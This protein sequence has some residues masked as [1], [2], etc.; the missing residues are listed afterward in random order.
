MVIECDVPVPVDDGLVLRAD[1]FAPDGRGPL[2]GDPHLRPLREGARLPGRLRRPVAAHDGAAP[3]R[4]AAARATSTRTGRSS[5]RRSGCRTATPASGWTRGA[6]AGRRAVLDPFSAGRPAIS[7]SASSGRRRSHGAAARSGLN[8]VSYYAMNQWHVAA[9]QPA[10]PG[11]DLRLGG[12]RRLLPGRHPPRRDPVLLLG[13]LVRQAG[14]RGPA[15]GRGARPAQRRSPARPWP[16]RRRSAGDELAAARVPLRR[17]DRAPT[18]STTSFYRDRSANWERITVPLLTAANW[19]GQGLHTRGNF[20]GFTQRRGAAHKWLEVHGL[21]HWTHF[22]TDYGVGP[23]ETVL[24]L[25]PARRRQRLAGP[26]A[27]AAAGPPSGRVRPAGG[28]GVAAGPHPLGAPLPAAG[29][30][31]S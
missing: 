31:P 7:T 15:R 10:A 20:E 29:L 21:E 9:L 17:G 16:A 13:E 12:R 6:R 22:Y 24:R 23:A 19:G 25:F 4:R 28:T 3:R 26:A 11:R 1:V 18:R 27:G 14:H 8:G 5:T 2:P 30:A